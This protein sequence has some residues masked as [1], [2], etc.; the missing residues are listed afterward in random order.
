M[1]VRFK[2][3]ETG[4][5]IE[6]EWPLAYQPRPAAVDQSSVA[7]RLAVTAS[8]FGEW[9]STSPYAAEVTLPALQ[10]LAAGLP[11]TFSPDP[12]PQQLSTMI[13]QARGIVGK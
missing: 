8:A 2:V 4:E 3:P 10:N 9:L 11:E 13:Q 1:R 6:Q 5:Y 7:M 12:R